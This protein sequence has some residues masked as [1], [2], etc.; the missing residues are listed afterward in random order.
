LQLNP[1]KVDE[2]R[3]F[4]GIFHY[5]FVHG[6]NVLASPDEERLEFIQKI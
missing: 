5:G 4:I 1:Y 2:I 3:V 6:V